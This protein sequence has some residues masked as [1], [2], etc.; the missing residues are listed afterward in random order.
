VRPSDLLPA[1]HRLAY[2]RP[3]VELVKNEVGN[4][5]VM[6]RDG[7]YIGYLDLRE[8]TLTLFEDED[9]DE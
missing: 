5:A 3:D 7:T 1:V 4:L 6:D 2:E 8:G 9:E